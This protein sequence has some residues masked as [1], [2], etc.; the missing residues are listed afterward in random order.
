VT[1]FK[2]VLTTLYKQH[3]PC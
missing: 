3:M 2:L 1:L